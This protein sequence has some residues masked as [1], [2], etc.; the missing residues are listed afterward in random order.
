MDAIRNALRE[1]PRG[2]VLLGERHRETGQLRYPAM[3][4]DEEWESLELSGEGEL[5]TYSTVR[6]PVAGFEPPLD[7]GYVR[8]PEGLLVFAPLAVPEGTTPRI[9]QRARLRTGPAG[10]G[11][12]LER[13]VYRFEL[14]GGQHS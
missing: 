8:L 9:G 7:V 10:T 11:D 6:M 12:D 14:I 4:A 5:F 3:G 13:L 2:W 1:T